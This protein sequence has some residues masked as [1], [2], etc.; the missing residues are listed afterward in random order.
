MPLGCRTRRFSPDARKWISCWSRGQRSHRFFGGALCHLAGTPRT[1]GSRGDGY[2]VRHSAARC[3]RIP[4]AGRSCSPGSVAV[5]WNLCGP[6]DHPPRAP[7]LYSPRDP[8]VRG[9]CGEVTAAVVHH[10]PADA[11]CRRLLRT[12][13]WCTTALLQS[14]AWAGCRASKAQAP[15]VGDPAT[16][17]GCNSPGRTKGRGVAR[18]REFG[19]T[20][21]RCAE[22]RSHRVAARPR[23]ALPPRTHAR[24]RVHAFA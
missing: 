4:H 18:R 24:P 19:S 21:Q 7:V 1:A 11:L 2:A 13:A 23:A 15:A 5:H 16:H 8:T 20:A 12:A 22:R 9:V 14:C 6:Q 3:Y 10:G 17:D